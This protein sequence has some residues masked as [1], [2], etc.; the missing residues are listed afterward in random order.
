MWALISAASISSADKAL[1]S[2]LLFISD[3][4]NENSEKYKDTDSEILLY[5]MNLT[6]KFQIK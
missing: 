4:I 2:R 1:N 5:R 6:N 3:H